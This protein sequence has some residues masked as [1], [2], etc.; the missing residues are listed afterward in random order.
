MR[1]KGLIA[2]LAGLT[3]VA[4]P[5]AA[6]EN[7][8]PPPRPGT[9][10]V[11]A[12]TSAE[13]ETPAT[14]LAVE[15]SA[16]VPAPRPED[17]LQG[18]ELRLALAAAARGDW[19][20]AAALAEQRGPAAAD[21]VEWQRLRRGRGEFA[22]Y[23]A[24]LSENGNWPGLALLRRRGES[25]IPEGAA[26]ADV[27]AYFAAQPPQTGHGAL[28]LAEALAASGRT[29]DAETTVLRAWRELEMGAT[30]EAAILDAYG[31]TVAPA[32]A[33]RLD[34]LLWRGD[35]SGVL[36]AMAR[37]DA[38]RKALAE[39]RIALQ[40]EEAGV[41]AAIEAVPEALRD[42]GG[43]AYDRMIWRIE[44]RRRDEAADLIISQSTSAERL[45]R[46]QEWAEWRR[47][48]ARQEMR[49]GNGQRAY[50][51]AAN[52]HIEKTDDFYPYADL[53]WLA[54]YLALTYLDDP[55]TALAHFRRHTAVVDTPISLSRGHYWE[56]RA[57]AA[58][59][60]A[61][62]AMAA[63]QR[64]AVHQTAF[65]GQLSAEKA[66]VPLDPALTGR[67]EPPD[68]REAGFVDS[69]VF[70]AAVLWF[71]AGERWETVRFLSH[72]AESTPVE[73]LE[74]L[75][76]FALSLG[77]PF[78][79]VRVSKQI[80]R[81]GAVPIR[82]YFP[83][84]DLGVDLPVEEALALAVAR[85]ESEFNVA[86][87]SPAGARGLMQ[88]MPGTARLVSGQLGLAYRLGALTTDAVYNA[89]LGSAYLA[90]LIEEFGPNYALVS[91]GYN[92][93]PG[94][95]RRWV[96][97]YGDP[98]DPGTDPVDWVEHIPFR[99]TRNYVMRVTE[100][101][102]VYRARLTG[103]VGAVGLTELLTAR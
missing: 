10:E 36:R 79:A 88:L 38:G 68:W 96:E 71:D 82:A 22:D 61:E 65:Y 70:A 53:E 76:E 20:I 9:G 13:P 93:G 63:W 85:R 34:L 8:R 86:A 89:T 69:S 66:G 21:I 31:D 78:V 26:P 84:Q 98:R 23:L 101:V 45:G 29:D 90:D 55:E 6:Q 39:A 72:L 25:S 100:S 57:L 30:E 12:S 50:D 80:V 77:D 92:A 27:L 28:R 74:A 4:A 64:G 54:G 51:L 81:E 103:E 5:A 41:D 62:A 44:K 32:H 56:G 3:L 49:A 99:E 91:A 58:M 46:P 1:R 95:P 37:V 18:H 43:L 33:A 14:E 15:A 83:L 24:F 11:V 19:D 102:P 59:G 48:L 73:E 97:L 17:L 47:V 35:R 67:A 40:R 52:H 42:H 16:R 7:M 87:V 94:R 75:G 60:D 2:A